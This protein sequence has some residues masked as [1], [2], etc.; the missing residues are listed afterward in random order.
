MSSN[1]R[2]AT[3]PLVLAGVVVQ[4]AAFAVS[5]ELGEPTAYAV[6]AV[7]SAGAL[8]LGTLPGLFVPPLAFVLLLA[9]GGS[10]F[11]YA[12]AGGALLLALA[13]IAT[14]RPPRKGV[15]G[16]AAAVAIGALLYV[17]W[18]FLADFGLVGYALALVGF[19][20][21]AGALAAVAGAGGFDTVFA[22]VGACILLALGL[23]ILMIVGRQDPGLVLEKA[24]NP[25]VQRSFY[26]TIF[27]P[28]LAT[29]FTLSLGVPLAYLLARGFPGRPLVESLVDLPL[30]VPHSVAGLAVLFAFGRNAAFPNMDVYPTL[31]GMVLAMAFV[32]APFA[33]N[34]AREGFEAT[35]DHLAWAARS[36]GANRW[37][38]FKRVEAPLAVRGVLTG[39]VLA[40]A[41]CVSEFGAVAVVAYNVDV[42]Y[43]PAGSDVTAQHAPVYIFRTFTS[44]G[45]DDSGAVAALLLV[46]VAVIF[47]VVRTVAYDDGG[48]P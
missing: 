46:L 4:L 1:S 8:A 29:L 23:P 2:I 47:V 44:Q 43:P 28:L 25:E 9:L 31:L 3:R 22:L 35:D 5:L 12:G 17:S 24:A 38:T 14:D 40:W 27:A 10:G 16:L 41:R 15:V 42:F 21:L 32:S 26:L 13:L 45:L 33:V 6:F 20:A 34:A 18:G 7:L 37:E 19:V 30:V 11:L 48:W 36:L 39:G